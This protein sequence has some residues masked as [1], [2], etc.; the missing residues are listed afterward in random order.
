MT[1]QKPLLAASLKKLTADDLK[2]PVYATPKLDGIRALKVNGEMVSRTLKP[3]RNSEIS[4]A[5]KEL[6]PNGSDGEI[7]SGKT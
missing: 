7:L 4:K 6:L 1:I 3:I 5:L 2:F